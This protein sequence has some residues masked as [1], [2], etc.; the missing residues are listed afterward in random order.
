MKK[1]LMYAFCILLFGC[2]V[3][4]NYIPKTNYTSPYN[5]PIDDTEMICKRLAVDTIISDNIICTEG[6]SSSYKGTFFDTYKEIVLIP[7]ETLYIKEI[8]D[9]KLETPNDIRDVAFKICTIKVYHVMNE[10]LHKRSYCD[11][12]TEFVYQQLKNKNV[13]P[14]QDV[15]DLFTK[16]TS[17]KNDPLGINV[18]HENCRGKL[19]RYMTYDNTYR[20]F[21]DDC[22]KIQKE[23]KDMCDKTTRVFLEAVGITKSKGIYQSD[24]PDIDSI[25]FQ[26]RIS[27]AVRKL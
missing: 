6:R 18:I 21:Y 20:E 11:C 26:E 23:S 1:S 27:N 12:A 2:E 9:K 16:N 15:I 7:S 4:K 8:Y 22:V 3:E 19:D 5:A 17:Y 14:G 13:V 25:E 10:S 24:M